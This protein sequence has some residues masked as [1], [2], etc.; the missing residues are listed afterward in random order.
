MAKAAL[1][2]VRAPLTRE[3]IIDTAIAFTDTH[4]LSALT[5]RSLATELGVQPMSLYHH[6]DNKDAIV[7]GMIDALLASTEMA[8]TAPDW[9]SW[10]KA[11]FSSLRRLSKDHPGALEAFYSAP[12]S[13]P[14]AANASITGFEVFVAAGMP[15][16]YALHAVHSISLAAL[17][18]AS[19]E[20]LDGQSYEEVQERRVEHAAALHAAHPELA[21]VTA[22]E[23]DA[24]DPWE[25][26]A[27]I[28]ILGLEAQIAQ[29]SAH[30]NRKRK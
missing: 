12:T 1:S 28:L 17:G 18:L 6:V 20:R 26:T 2:A 19:D 11:V 14:T 23:L 13:G 10:V 8:S 3:R 16:V 24:I 7:A 25:F 22:E 29:L 27:S 21:S 4:G 15:K 5:M 30:T 9:R